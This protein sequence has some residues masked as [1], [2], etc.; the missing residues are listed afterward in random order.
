VLAQVER[1]EGVALHR[2]ALGEVAL[3]KVVAEAVQKQR[4]AAR[5]FAPCGRRTSVASA[6]PS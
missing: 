3:E 4:R 6:R 2:E 1:V 5:R